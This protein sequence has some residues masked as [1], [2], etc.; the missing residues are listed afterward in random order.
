MGAAGALSLVP[1]AVA[2]PRL[3]ARTWQPARSLGWPGGPGSGDA[4]P[5]LASGRDAG[6]TPPGQRDALRPPPL[7]SRLLKSGKLG[8]RAF[9]FPRTMSL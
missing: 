4:A 6:E 9:L 3:R 7:P 2:G 1:A 8:S 5:A